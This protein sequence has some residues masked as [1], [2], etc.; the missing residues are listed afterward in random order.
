[1]KWPLQFFTF[2]II[3]FGVINPTFAENLSIDTD[4]PS[5]NRDR[6]MTLPSIASKED[7]LSMKTWLES[8][9][10]NCS[11]DSVLYMAIH[12]A[13]GINHPLTNTT[14]ITMS[15]GRDFRLGMSF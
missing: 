14:N 6:A 11:N 3:L 9:G 4:A 5:L 10:I 15:G 1:M 2:L 12:L 7:L 8:A 13:M